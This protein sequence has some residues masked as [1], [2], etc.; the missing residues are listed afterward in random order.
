MHAHTRSQY[1]RG[2]W[3]FFKILIMYE[4]K[5][6]KPILIF[7]NR[8]YL[9]FIHAHM[10]WTNANATSSIKKKKKQF[11]LLLRNNTISSIE[12]D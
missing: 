5:K 8:F 1:R 9:H 11:Y 7:R 3:Q 4:I 2:L 6:F 10:R 12:F